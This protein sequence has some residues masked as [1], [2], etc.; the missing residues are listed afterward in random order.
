MDAFLLK[1][2]CVAFFGGAR[3][4]FFKKQNLQKSLLFS[5]LLGVMNSTM[6]LSKMEISAM[7]IHME[8]SKM[9]V[10]KM[11][12]PFQRLDFQVP[13]QRLWAGTWYEILIFL[14]VESYETRYILFKGHA[15]CMW[16]WESKGVPPMP[17]LP[18]KQGPNDVFPD[19]FLKWPVVSWCKIFHLLSWREGDD[20]NNHQHIR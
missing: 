6:S 10:W 4:R 3:W 19:H 1:L 9:E 13:C 16:L 7:K 12:L 5:K 2:K 17:T 8:D 15:S 11:I 20:N 18:W 14:Q